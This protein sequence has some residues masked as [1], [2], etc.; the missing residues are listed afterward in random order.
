MLRFPFLN[1]D[2]KQVLFSWSQHIAKKAWLVVSISK[3]SLCPNAK[4]AMF[5]R[6]GVPKF[7]WPKIYFTSSQ[8]AEI[9]QFN[10]NI[11][12]QVPGRDGLNECEALG[13]VVLTARSSERLAQLRSIS[14]VFVSTFRS[15]G[16][17]RQSWYDSAANTWLMC[18]NRKLYHKKTVFLLPWRY[19]TIFS[20]IDCLTIFTAQV[21]HSH[22]FWGKICLVYTLS[23][24][25]T[26]TV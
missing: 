13:E 15:L 16:Q 18:S 8:A 9:C 5:I 26:Y 4:Y 25:K 17:K 20:V 22:M 19:T 24:I 6:S 12:S 21:V 1:Y 3:W 7:F 11:T 10:V 14:H 23:Q 2:W